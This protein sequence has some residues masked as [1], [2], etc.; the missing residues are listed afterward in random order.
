MVTRQTNRYEYRTVCKEDQRL[1]PYMAEWLLAW[2]ASMNIQRC[3]GAALM[4]YTAKLTAKY[5]AKPEKPGFI[6]NNVSERERHALQRTQIHFLNGRVVGLVVGM[7]EAVQRTWG[8]NMSAGMGVTHHCVRV[9]TN[10][11]E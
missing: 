1:S 9:I 10:T 7:P 4:H 5:V 3:T 6:H 11:H 2:G 8:F